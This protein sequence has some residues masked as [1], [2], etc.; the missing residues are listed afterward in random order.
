MNFK[1]YVHQIDKCRPSTTAAPVN[2]SE[3]TSQTDGARN[4]STASL[5]EDNKKVMQILSIVVWGCTIIYICRLLPYT[6][7]LAMFIFV[8]GG[9]ISYLRGEELQSVRLVSIEHLLYGIDASKR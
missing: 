7:L 9:F 1:T 8:V 2:E 5:I 4:A 6:I 3:E